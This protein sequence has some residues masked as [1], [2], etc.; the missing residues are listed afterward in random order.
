MKKVL[1]KNEFKESL[2]LIKVTKELRG[3]YIHETEEKSNFF[4]AIFP[5]SGNDYKFM[6]EGLYK[7]G[8]M[9]L[10]TNIEIY[11]ETANVEY[12]LFYMNNVYKITNKKAF[13][14][15]DLKTYLLEVFKNA[16]SN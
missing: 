11:E 3:G 9:K 12:R 4:G 5:L 1:I 15:S 14:N 13:P 2:I 8:T 6:L 10:Y 7:T 16:K